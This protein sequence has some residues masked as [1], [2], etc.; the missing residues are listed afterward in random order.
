MP[1]RDPRIPRSAL[2]DG[3]VLCLS[4]ASARLGEADEL[5]SKGFLTQ[6]AVL[7]SYA[8][9]EF[10]KAVLLRKA[11]E[12][13]A[14]PAAIEGFYD[15]DAKLAAA[16]LHLSP[17]HLRLDA[18]GFGSGRF[19]AGAFGTARAVDLTA[20]LSGLYVDWKGSWAHGVQ[21]DP[22][23]LSESSKGVQQAVTTAMMDWT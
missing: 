8:V 2:R 21:V 23:V 9:E 13:R 14:D 20:R 12:S 17:E 10:G 1:S 3:I 16:T 18:G 6:A 11:W 7:F 19:A 15:H 4:V 5:L 22:E